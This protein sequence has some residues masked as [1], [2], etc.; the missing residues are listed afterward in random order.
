[1]PQAEYNPAQQEGYHLAQVN[2]ARMLA[3]LTNPLMVDFVAQLQ[4]INA[5]ADTSPGF[6]WRLQSEDGDAT[7]I[8]GFDDDLI[9]VNLTVW[10][11]IKA[12]SDYVYRSQH[13]AV[14]RDRHRWFE[15]SNQPTSALWW[16]IAGH[17][18]TIESAKERLEHLRHHG[19]TPHAFSFAKPFP[20][21]S[22]SCHQRSK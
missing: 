5:I 4:K 16:I 9:L 12:L 15:K 1:M 13:G 11:S 20:A 22:S 6:V 14:M 21:S 8:R 19:S 2:I 3:P 17:I 18:P 10:E 7:S